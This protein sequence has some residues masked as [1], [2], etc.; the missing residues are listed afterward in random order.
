V[1]TTGAR[2]PGGVLV[3]GGDYKSLGVVRSLGRR[4]IRVWVLRD[5]HVLAGLSRYCER[6]LRWQAATEAEKVERLLAIARTHGLR[7]WALFPADEEPAALL[8]RNRDA[9]G[10]MYRLTILTPWETLRQAYDKRLTYRLAA[11]LGIDHPRT[12]T[13]RDRDDVEK[14]DGGYPAILKPAYRPELNRFTTSKAWPV[15]DHDSLMARYEEACAL[16][17][18]DLI[19]IQELVPGGGECQF[20][21]AALCE[22]GRPIA[23]LVARRTRQWPMDFGRASTYV[24]TLDD[25]E[26]EEIGRR[27]LAALRFDGIVELEF[28]RDPRDGRLKLLDINPRIWGWHTLSG[29]A[30]VDF[31]YLLWRMVSGQPVAPTRG[32]AGV[33]WVRALTDVPQVITE[34][35]A[36]RLSPLAYLRSLRGPIEFAVLAADDPLPAL[37]ELPATVYLLAKRRAGAARRPIV[38][39][40]DVVGATASRNAG[41]P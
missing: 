12:V 22:S 37:L 9:L 11:E 36:G 31:P 19:M 6:T 35:R 16:I 3:I 32:R 29:R 1:S 17:D 30:G 38:R 20:S 13:P 23:S 28:K 24:E 41:P 34:I 27:V 39:A 14:Y 4:G 25:P 33:R 8:A 21:F 5:D 18:P 26:V 7:G 15:T 10:E 40:S 2:E